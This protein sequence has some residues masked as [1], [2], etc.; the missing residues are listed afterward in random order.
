MMLRYLGETEAADRLE[1]AVAAV[2]RE[3]KDVTYDLKPN[4]DDPAAVGTREMG[5]AIVRAMEGA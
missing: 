4:R 3:G 1:A 2:I 5:E